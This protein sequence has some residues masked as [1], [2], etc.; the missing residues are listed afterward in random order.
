MKNKKS[1]FTLTEMMLTVSIMGFLSA[2][3]AVIFT[4]STRNTLVNQAKIDTQR[5]AR[6]ALD[7]INRSMRQAK[8]ST[9]TVDAETG[10]PPYSSVTFTAVDDSAWKFYQSGKSLY[11]VKNG[12]TS[13]LCENLRYIAFTYSR[14][15][16][17]N[18]IS[19]SITTEEQTY[20]SET[21]VL[22]LSVEQVRIMND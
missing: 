11:S 2:V 20:Q 21:K 4:Q 18:I 5:E 1:G 3:G 19:V 7:I 13:T 15:D 16:Q 6:T 10:Q 22:Q 17:S 8:A 12:S 14:T 9:I